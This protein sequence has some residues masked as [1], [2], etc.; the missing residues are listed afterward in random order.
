MSSSPATL[1]DFL[2]AARGHLSAAAVSPSAVAPGRDIDEYRHGLARLVTVL[3]RYAG[4][5]TREIRKLPSG[6]LADVRPWYQ[7]SVRAQEALASAAS[8]LAAD[9]SGGLQGDGLSSPGARH[10]SAAAASLAAG[11]DLM[12]GHFTMT[13]SGARLHQSSWAVA[14]TSPAVQQ[15]LLTEITSLGAQAADAA[16]ATA[17]PVTAGGRTT[18]AQRRIGTACEWL[19]L[20]QDRVSAVGR[21]D[22]AAV[23]GREVLN[24][25]PAN[26]MPSRRVPEDA[27]L[28][29]EL[30]EAVSAAAQRARHAAWSA[31]QADPFSPAISATSWHRIAEA[32]TV[33][34]HNCHLLYT[35]LAERAAGE[36]AGLKDQ[37]LRAA[38]QTRLARARWLAAALGI[39]EITTEVRGHISPA[40]IEAAELALWTGRLAYADPGWTLASGPSHP[41]RSPADLAAGQTELH[42][43]VDAIHQAS[44]AFSSLAIANRE[45]ASKAVQA[46]RL[47]IPAR[48]MAERYNTGRGIP[49]RVPPAPEPYAM[50][51]LADCHDTAVVTART[52]EESA[53]IV[54][55]LGTPSRVLAAAE[56]AIREQP[57]RAR[58]REP[59]ARTVTEP[60]AGEPVAGP[61]EARLRDM[62]VTDVRLLWRA[63]SIDEAAQQV[64]REAEAEQ[65]PHRQQ[66]TSAPLSAGRA[67]DPAASLQSG[68]SG[69]NL[70]A[71]R[72]ELEAE[73]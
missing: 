9:A 63:T 3:S 20:A 22:A 42:A 69:Q 17:D 5:L 12:Q 66:P 59:A 73:P 71:V 28:V 33:A 50:S 1:G 37:L 16:E 62:G 47:L 24:A 34:S 38:G 23:A 21:R 18:L 8:V 2:A 65:R 26:V 41:P 29:T 60:A 68:G 52:A 58:G 30:C 27:E 72:A 40:A 39:Q 44:D 56:A 45:Q 13:Q 61:V 4:D 43:V 51:L 57:E 10:L 53:G 55:R 48:S 15:A 19:R 54:A 11:R 32:G 6:H 64:I 25:I 7:A 49:M 35:A 14:I 36:D 67:A 70:T 46:H 31:T